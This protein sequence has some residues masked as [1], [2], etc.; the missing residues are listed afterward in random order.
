MSALRTRLQV[1]LAPI[2]AVWAPLPIRIAGVV[3]NADAQSAHRFSLKDYCKRCAKSDWAKMTEM[4]PYFG[5]FVSR[6][7][8]D[9]ADCVREA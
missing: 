6:W 1:R 3:F 5:A 4:S 2:V 7:G 8:E 9:G